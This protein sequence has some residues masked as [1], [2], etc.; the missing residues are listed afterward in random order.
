[1]WEIR[2]AV[3]MDYLFLFG[4]VRSYDMDNQINSA[5]ITGGRLYLMYEAGKAAGFLA[6]DLE[7][8]VHTVLTYYLCPEHRT[9]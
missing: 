8:D 4:N 6:Y 1:M 3:Y 9:V 2:Q 5:L 7:K